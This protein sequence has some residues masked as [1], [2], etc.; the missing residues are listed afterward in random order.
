[1]E[2]AMQD[3]ES[4]CSSDDEVW[5]GPIT[6]KEMKKAMELRRRTMIHRPVSE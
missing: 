6:K 3:V 5:Y 2:R 1:M 4:C